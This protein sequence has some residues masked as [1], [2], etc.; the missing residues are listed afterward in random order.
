[1]RR[2]LKAA[3]ALVALVAIAC[4]D[5]STI[6]SIPAGGGRGGA[7][8]EQDARSSNGGT[9]STDASSAGDSEVSA[10]S[11]AAIDTMVYETSLGEVGADAHDAFDA[12][13]SKDGAIVAASCSGGEH[14]VCID[15]EDGRVVAPWT[16]PASHARVDEGNAAHGRY[17]MH[18]FDLHSIP[19]N[20]S[21]QPALYLHT[22]QMRGIK[23][24]LWGR[25]YLYMD[26]GAPVGH[27]AIVRANDM[28]TNWH[29]VGF[30][31]NG[32][33]PNRGTTS[34]P[35]SGAFF[36]DW[37]TG[38]VGNPE[39]YERSH[40][41]IAQKQ[42]VCVEFYFDGSTPALPR[43]WG[44]GTEVVFD[45][46]GGPAQTVQKAVQFV[47]FDIGIVFYHGGSLTTY[48]GDTPPYITDEWLDDIALD[49][50]RIGCL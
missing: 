33:A 47:S 14:P 6:T 46:F 18:L 15:F 19:K 43:V 42:W 44:D 11:D 2:A 20:G 45:D 28:Q 29:E 7:L 9:P 38:V 10:P 34:S 40:A 3:C 32:A 37:H 23:D 21:G 25:F 26:P 31:A 22:S 12:A 16:L 4:G 50:K 8:P 17:A 13:G 1:M 41:T 35:S 5:N 24:V 49:V 36:G 48:E 27:G 30:E 39:K